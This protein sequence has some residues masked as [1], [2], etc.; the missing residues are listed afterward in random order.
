[1]ASCMR[2]IML[3]YDKIYGLN[4]TESDWMK[5]ENGDINMIVD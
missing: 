4:W 5:D 1:M 3:L 2:T